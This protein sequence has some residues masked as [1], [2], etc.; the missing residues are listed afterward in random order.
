MFPDTF[1][2]FIKQRIRWSRN[3]VRTYLTALWKGWLWRAP[4]V[5]KVMVLQILLTPMTMGL[6]LYY[7]IASRLD[8]TSRGFVLAA[9][10]LLGGRLVRSYSH[11]RRHP[12]DIFLLPVY[13]LV[14]IL[15]ALPIKLYATVTMNRQ[16]WLTRTAS[17]V[18]ADGQSAQTLVSPLSRSQ[19]E[20]AA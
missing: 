11:L 17:S 10:W 4:H 19:P 15:V 2:A 16:G 8:F 12:L 20:V 9:L 14:V 18:G 13:E 5:T 7:L 1:A 6:A 3:S